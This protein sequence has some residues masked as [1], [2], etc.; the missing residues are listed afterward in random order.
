MSSTGLTHSAGE[1]LSLPLLTAK[2]TLMLGS[3]GQTP[4]ALRLTAGPKE[5]NP[6]ACAGGSV[7]FEL[8][9]VCGPS[10]P[11]D[12]TLGSGEEVQARRARTPDPQAGRRGTLS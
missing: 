1:C 8:S 12:S 7:P 11:L 4:G 9:D 3:G 2:S 10:R 6:A 5:P